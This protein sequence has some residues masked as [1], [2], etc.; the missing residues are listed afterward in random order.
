ME[1]EWDNYFDIRLPQV[2]KSVINTYKT[3]QTKYQKTTET[4]KNKLSGVK[5]A[6]ATRGS[7]F[8]N[9]IKRKYLSMK[10]RVG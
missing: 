7:S 1:C 5:T 2:R 9:A 6:M 3:F 4:T 8:K 10:N